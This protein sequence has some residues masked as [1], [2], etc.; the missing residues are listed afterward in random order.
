MKN[1]ADKRLHMVAGSGLFV[2]SENDILSRVSGVM[3][4]YSTAA[5]S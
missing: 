1:V 2:S 3:Q 4:L 5:V